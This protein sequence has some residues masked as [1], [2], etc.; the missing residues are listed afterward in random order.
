[1][2][3]QLVSSRLHFH[4]WKLLFGLPSLTMLLVI[5]LKLEG[6]SKIDFFFLKWKMQ[7]EQC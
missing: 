5:A 7:M 1:M 2:Q 6:E 4:F 3:C